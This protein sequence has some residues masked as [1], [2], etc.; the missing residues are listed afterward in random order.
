MATH[1]L[2]SCLQHHHMRLAGHMGHPNRLELG[3]L[4]RG[5]FAVG[6]SGL[7]FAWAHEVC[8]EDNEERALVTAT[9]NEMAYVIQAWLPLV[10]W[11]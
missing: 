5:C 4:H 8:A 1:D 10:M 11:Q 6:L 9:M 3:M 7:C 2:R